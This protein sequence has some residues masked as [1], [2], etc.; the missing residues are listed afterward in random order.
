MW[1]Q[2]GSYILVAISEIFASITS[3]EYAFSKAPK[4]MRSLVMAVNLFMSAF[5]AALGEAFVYLAQDPLLVW[6]YGVAG[7]L[8]FVGG[9]IFWIMYIPLDRAEDK[10]VHPSIIESFP[11]LTR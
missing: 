6:N 11:L 9:I 10:Y 8:S 4:N 2:T 1:A 5:A 7:V 3:L